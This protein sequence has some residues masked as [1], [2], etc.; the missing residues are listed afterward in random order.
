MKNPLALLFVVLFFALTGAAQT[1]PDWT[2]KQTPFRIADSLYYVGSRDLAVYLITTPNGHILINANLQSSPPLIRES[3]EAL[4]F[5]WNDIRIV[6]NGQAHFDHVG[7]LAEILRETGARAFVMEGDADVVE[8][9]GKTDFAFGP[10][11]LFPKAHV[12]RVLHDGDKIS[13]GGIVLIARKTAGHTRGCTTFTMRTHLPGEPEGKLR[14]VVIAGGLTALPQY[15]LVD[16]PGRK[17]SYPG[18][19]ADFRKTYAIM[20]ALPCDIYLGAHGSYFNLAE[21]LE[22]LPK[23][24]NRVWMDPKGYRKKIDGYETDFK[25]LLDKQVAE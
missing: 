15:Q 14:N 20:R 19:A 2:A 6:L 21:K 24:G 17:A 23:E 11:E 7:G 3:V 25:E 8:S 13:L 1:N 18:I 5:R 12:S 16:K 4:H 10:E 22:R 9:G